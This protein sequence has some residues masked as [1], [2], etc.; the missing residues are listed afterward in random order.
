MGGRGRGEDASRREDDHGEDGDTKDYP[1]NALAT[2]TGI[3]RGRG[4]GIRP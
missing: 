4:G 3:G 1:E 2:T